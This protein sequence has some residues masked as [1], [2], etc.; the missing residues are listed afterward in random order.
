MTVNFKNTGSIPHDVT[1]QSGEKAK[2]NAGETVSV[3]VD[4]PAEGL[5]FICSDTGPRAAG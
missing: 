5:T 2:A 1:F 4:V 3:E